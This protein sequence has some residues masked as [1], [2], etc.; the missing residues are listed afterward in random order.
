[1][2]LLRVLLFGALLV[3]APAVL[4]QED[5]TAVDEAVPAMEQPSIATRVINPHSRRQWM[6]VPRL[7]RSLS[8]AISRDHHVHV[9][10]KG[11][12]CRWL[13]RADL[14]NYNQCCLAS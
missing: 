5:P 2:R 1:M 9:L 3:C 10:L 8:R 12:T 7:G 11:S 4:A 6:P 13:L 14:H